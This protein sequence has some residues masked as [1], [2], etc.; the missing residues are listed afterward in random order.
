VNTS[1]PTALATPQNIPKLT[2]TQNLE[3]TLDLGLS[4][5]D[6][7]AIGERIRN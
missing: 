7:K 1:T 3:K 5:K 4:E 6:S 2:S